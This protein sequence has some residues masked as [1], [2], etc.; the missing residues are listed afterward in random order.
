MAHMT[1]FVPRAFEVVLTEQSADSLF[2][3]MDITGKSYA[4]ICKA[5][6]ERAFQEQ[7]PDMPIE[8]PDAWQSMEKS[9]RSRTVMRLTEES[10]KN[11]DLAATN[12]GV[13]QGVLAS[14][15]TECE[16]YYS[17]SL[18]QGPQKP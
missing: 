3:L 12:S 8:I 16:I 9:N 11:L 13:S 17:L 18:L 4:Q 14:F 5:G 1:E 7:A 6:V 2:Q 10:H 15:L